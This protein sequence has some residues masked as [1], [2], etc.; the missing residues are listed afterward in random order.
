MV[1]IKG[2][3]TFSVPTYEIYYAAHPMNYPCAQLQNRQIPKGV[4]KGI[5]RSF[6]L[7]STPPFFFLQIPCKNSI[8]LLVVY[9]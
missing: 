4:I 7:K 3:L 9:V 6:L 8:N 5:R 1:I 2:L